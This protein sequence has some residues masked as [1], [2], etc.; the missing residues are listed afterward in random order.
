M[1]NGSGHPA[2]EWPRLGQP[3][4]SPAE[5]RG[6]AGAEEERDGGLPLHRD[7][8]QQRDGGEGDVDADELQSG[9]RPGVS[10]D[11]GA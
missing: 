11:A 2:G 6:A 3:G 1:A 5:R 10:G 8:Q 7:A 4:G 9:S